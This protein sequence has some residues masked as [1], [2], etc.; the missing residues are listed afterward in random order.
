MDGQKE[1]TRPRVLA[2]K[3]FLQTVHLRK[4]HLIFRVNNSLR[5]LQFCFD[6][7]NDVLAPL[8]AAAG[9]K[10]RQTPGLV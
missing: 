6:K 3:D 10:H 2:V 5:T 8:A 4:V 1:L 7:A 9:D